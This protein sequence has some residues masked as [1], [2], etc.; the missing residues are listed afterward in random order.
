MV[1]FLVAPR[2]FPGNTSAIVA[3]AKVTAAI[4]ASACQDMLV[5]LPSG[6]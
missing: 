6:N 2:P 5:S 1:W 3:A 4:R